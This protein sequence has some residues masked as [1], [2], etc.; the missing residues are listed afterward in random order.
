MYRSREWILERIRR[1]HERAPE[2]GLQELAM[3]YK[4]SRAVVAEALSL[5]LPE[6]RARR[7]SSV[8]DPVKPAIELMLLQELEA[9]A[10]RGHT[11]RGIVERLRVEEDFTAASYSTVR[12]YVRRRRIALAQE[13][14]AR[15]RRLPEAAP[16][17]TGPGAG[18][19][20]GGGVCAGAR[21]PAGPAL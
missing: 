7:R 18:A 19:D 21:V 6:R 1:D 8:L 20:G 17:L 11:I 9:A 4:V 13:A 14:R 3:R 5:P 16:A 15:A 2:T 10:R 12:D